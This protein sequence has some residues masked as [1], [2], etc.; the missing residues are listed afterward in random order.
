MTKKVLIVSLIVLSFLGVRAQSLLHSKPLDYNAG[1]SGSK[2]YDRISFHFNEVSENS[3]NAYFS[4]DK[5][6]KPLKGGIGLYG[7]RKKMTNHFDK[8]SKRY[9]L[10]KVGAAYSPKFIVKGKYQ[11]APSLVIDYSRFN[12]QKTSILDETNSLLV[13]EDSYGFIG[14]DIGV[15]ANSKNG[16]LGYTF[17]KQYGEANTLL[18]SFQTGYILNLDKKINLI[19]DGRY[20]HGSQIDDLWRTYTSQINMA[21]QYGILFV[22]AGLNDTKYVSGMLG[23]K[24]INLKINA[25]YHILKP[26]N[27]SNVELGVQYVFNKNNEEKLQTP[28]KKWLI[29]LKM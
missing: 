6:I 20:N 2:T 14:S 1:F 27:I 28:F 25:A 13:E 18:H 26:E 12:Y 24:L 8:S 9:E 17:K 11:I 15:L 21:Y 19:F 22:G 4:Y 7:N 29:K 16:Y 3:R 23:V 10:T 5:L